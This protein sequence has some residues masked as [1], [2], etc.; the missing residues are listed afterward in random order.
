MKYLFSAP[1]T[2]LLLCRTARA[3]L[4]GGPESE[5]TLACGRITRKPPE[6]TY[7]ESHRQRRPDHPLTR[8][9]QGPPPR[10]FSL[11]LTKAQRVRMSKNCA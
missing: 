10:A 8:S 11:N 2:G 5:K 1:V 6:L 7:A 9:E 3:L 4:R